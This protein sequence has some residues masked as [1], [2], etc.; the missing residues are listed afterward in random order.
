[1]MKMRPRPAALLVP[2]L[3]GLSL[4]ACD[5][6]VTPGNADAAPPDADADAAPAKLLKVSYQG[7]D[8]DVNVLALKPAAVDAGGGAVLLSEVVL[9]ALPGKSLPAL[10]A[11]FRAVDGFDPASKS[12]C[13]GLLPVPGDRLDRGFVSLA[14]LNLAWAVELQYPGC[15]HVKALAQILLADK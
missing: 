10:A 9:S 15:L 8:H 7:A 3:A 2:W 11:G 13:D 12:N 5:Q 4:A 6:T 1:M 14:T